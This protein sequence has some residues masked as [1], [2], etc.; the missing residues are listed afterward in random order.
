MGG[1]VCNVR[2]TYVGIYVGM[3]LNCDWHFWRLLLNSVNG[4][5]CM[6]TSFR[7]C[8]VKQFSDKGRHLQ[9]SANANGSL[10]RMHCVHNVH[11]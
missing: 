8:S 3:S 9:E 1:Q 5:P 10:H 11:S 6:L 7:S 4:S 2:G